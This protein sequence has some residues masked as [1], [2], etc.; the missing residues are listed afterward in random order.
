[1]TLTIKRTPIESSN[2]KSVGYDQ[3]TKTLAIEFVDG[4]IYH[5]EDVKQDTYNDLLGAK[6][7]G[8]FVHANIKGVYKHAKQDKE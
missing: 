4:T 8:K 7:V 3:D 1:M 5:Y 2:V 6:S